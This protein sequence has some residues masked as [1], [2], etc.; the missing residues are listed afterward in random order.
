MR[1]FVI[2]DIHGC[3][4]AL[5]AV[6]DEIDPGAGDELIFLGDYIDRGPDSRNVIDQIIDLQS[7]C[8]VVALRGNHEIMMMGVLFGGLDGKFWMRGGGKATMTSYGGKLTKLPPAHV[9]FFQGLLPYYQTEHEIFIHA[10]YNPLVGVEAITEELLYW[11]HLTPPFPAPHCSGKRVFVGH[12][13]QLS[14]EV[15]DLGH[16]VCVDTYCFGGRYLTA[17]N[18]DTYEPIQADWHGHLRRQRSLAGWLLWLQSRWSALSGGGAR[19]ESGPV[20]KG[21]AEDSSAGELSE[22]ERE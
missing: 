19:S 18:L 2:G 20:K 8:N 6:V 4:K 22:S 16:L 9:E 15:L 11:A 21:Q 3:S 14:G 10:N 7:S 5:R 1:R 12:S 17:L 13:P